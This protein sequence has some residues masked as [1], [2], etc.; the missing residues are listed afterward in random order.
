MK[1]KDKIYTKLPNYKLL[2]LSEE[3]WEWTTITHLTDVQLKPLF[4][5][6]LT[7]INNSL[8]KIRKTL[9]SFIQQSY[10]HNHISS[11]ILLTDQL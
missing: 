5:Y 8:V 1:N 2:E 3:L 7:I 6:F 4:R 11:I 9:D 10:G